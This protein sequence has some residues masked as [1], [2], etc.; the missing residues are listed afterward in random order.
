MTTV[1]SNE[2]LAYSRDPGCRPAS[3]T[4]ALPGRLPVEEPVGALRHVLVMEE[5]RKIREGS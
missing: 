2:G 1:R 5:I 3:S 4:R